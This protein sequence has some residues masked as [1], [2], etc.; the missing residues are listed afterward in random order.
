MTNS[1]EDRFAFWAKK[2]S[3]T[4]QERC[5]NAERQIR[6][7]IQSSPKL[8]NRDIYVFTQGSYR[9]RVNVRKDSDVDVGVLCREV[10]YFDLPEGYS[11]EQF[12]L[13]SP[14]S[15]TYGEFKN[16]LQEALVARFGWG[17]VTRGNKA[18]DIKANTYRVEAD[19]APFFKYRRYSS[20]GRYHEGVKL[21]PNSG[22][23]V[24]NWPEQHYK[25]G[26]AKNDATRRS[27]KGMVRILKAL[28]NEM[29]DN[30]ALAAKPIPGFLVECLVWNTP[31]ECLAKSTYTAN[32]RATLAHLFNHTMSDEKC[33]EWTEVSGLKWLLRGQKP[34]TRQQAH[35][36]LDAAWN[37]L[38]LE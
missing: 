24:I 1:W 11:R 37:Y 22:G 3:D 32:V 18:F 21:L 23:T 6:Q 8:K 34:W 27:Y 4:E 13:N 10:F 12:G 28:R 7:A 19:V 29:D 30:G 20:S 26:V 33:A 35:E 15:Y 9:N 5:Q 25:N 16:E 17:A 14:A 2:P 36:W 38:G 31:N